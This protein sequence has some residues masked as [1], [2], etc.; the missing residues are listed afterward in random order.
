[1]QTES[2]QRMTTLEKLIDSLLSEL[3]LL[4]NLLDKQGGH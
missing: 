3:P 1:M 4:E 2:V